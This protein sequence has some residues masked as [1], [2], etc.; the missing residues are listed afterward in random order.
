[1]RKINLTDMV[2]ELD[3]VAQEAF[4]QCSSYLGN[5]ER[6]EGKQPPIPLDWKGTSRLIAARDGLNYRVEAL[7]WHIGILQR[8]KTIL[9]KSIEESWFDEHRC[10]NI[11]IQAQRQLGYLLDDVVFNAMS[12]FDYLSEF[13]FAA[14][15]PGLRGDK[16]WNKVIQNIQKITDKALCECLA[17][18][19]AELVKALNKY[20]GHVIHNQPEMGDHRLKTS[21][22]S[23]GVN[24][25]HDMKLPEKFYNLII[26][27]IEDKDRHTQVD[28]GIFIFVEK[29]IKHQ[30]N[31]LNS[32][33]SFEYAPASTAL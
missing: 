14:H 9:E 31:I 23:D 28:L 25:T 8:E 33:A 7:V 26:D 6:I 17:N 18:A 4:V 5:S 29:C 15:F 32:L 1:M 13:V 11:R 19:E 2:M 10:F 22:G 16:R 12:S 27:E 20:R 3:R 30:L 21:F 24:H